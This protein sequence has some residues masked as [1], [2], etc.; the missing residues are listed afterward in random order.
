M[1]QQNVVTQLFVVGEGIGDV[2]WYRSDE[3]CRSGSQESVLVHFAICIS[4]A[5]I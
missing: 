1:A 5:S 2:L 4:R 3:G